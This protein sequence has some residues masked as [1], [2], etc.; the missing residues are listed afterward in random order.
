MRA[1][2][3]AAVSHVAFRV[4]D[5]EACVEHATALIGLRESERSGASVF[6]T[7]DAS[8]HH[9]VEYIAAAENGLDHMGY[10]ARSP[11]AL[12]ELRRR[13]EAAGLPILDREPAGPVAESFTFLGP[14]QFAIEIHT[15]IGPPADPPPPGL[16]AAPNRLG[17][18]NVNPREVEPSRA[19]YADVLGFRVSDEVGDG[20]GY[21]MRC[22]ADHHA[23]A[24]LAGHGWFHHQAWEVQSVVDLGHVGDLLDE[25]G[26]RLLW[27][28][29]R[30]GVG[31]NVAAYFRDPTGSVV[32]LY[33]DMERIE[34]DD[35]EPGRWDPDDNRW[36]SLWTDFRPPSFRE[37]GVPPAPLAP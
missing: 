3:V 4:A 33:T 29:V 18:F 11:E 7:H 36:Y 25:R 31:R 24:I 16:V 20:D 32:E 6:L 26:E 8:V 1:D 2:L 5:P 12:A 19:L 35:A 34:A 27:G 21:F 22:N 28:P 17:H 10:E 23:I 15:P 37:Y 14:E 13:V 30:H 9:S